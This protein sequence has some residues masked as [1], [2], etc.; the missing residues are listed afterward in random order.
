MLFIELNKIIYLKKVYI[1]PF[2]NITI[3]Y[4]THFP[5]LI[6]ELVSNGSIEYK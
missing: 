3:I 5:S 4:L 1:A 2:T 6:G